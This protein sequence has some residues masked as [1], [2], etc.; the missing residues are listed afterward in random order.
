M[1]LNV[2]RAD[3]AGNITLLVL[4][5]VPREDRLSVAARLMEHTEFAAEQVGF[6]CEPHEGFDGRLE[7][8]G[9][10]FCGNASRACGI[11]IAK[12]R[13]VRGKAHL[14]LEV[15]GATRPVGVDVDM[16]VGFARAEAPL[17]G[18]STELSLGEA[19]GVLV[20]LG[21]I[22][23]FV[24]RHE[25]DAAILDELEPALRK[26]REEGS[27]PAMEAYGV[28]FLDDGH[29]TPLVKVPSAGTLF[30]EG[31]CGSGSLAAAVAESLRMENGGF[32]K[33]YIQPAGTVRAEIQR[34][35]FDVVAAY[36]GGAVALDEPVVVEI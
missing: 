2:V 13:G 16:E 21:G 15:S 33:D 10:E 14:T 27:F 9:G 6:V 19:K 8:A 18:P 36:I 34:K 12:Q 25:P 17:P 20:D 30:W 7:M 28:I 29:M 32:A 35:Q 11:L 5:P 26:M 31:S 3:P 1:K 24:T 23:H 22:V 4:D